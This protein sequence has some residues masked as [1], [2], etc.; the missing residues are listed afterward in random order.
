MCWNAE[1]SI[2]TFIYAIIS[3]LIIISL[4]WYPI[5]YSFIILSISL[6]Q[7]YEYFAWKNIHNK[8]IIHNLSIIGPFIIFLHIL[9]LNYAFLRGNERILAILIIIIIMIVTMIYNYKNNKF[10]MEVGKN[11]HLLW[12]WF[13]LPGILLIFICFFY[14]YPLAKK[15]NKLLFIYGVITLLISYYY[16]YKYKTWGTMWCYFSNLSWFGLIIYAFIIKK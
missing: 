11:G 2:N 10:D 6:I 4:N 3:F 13:D 9:L 15:E 1:V 8:K 14:L 7:L 12:H 16:Y 5:I